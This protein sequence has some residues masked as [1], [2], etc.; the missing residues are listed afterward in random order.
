MD[1]SLIHPPTPGIFDLLFRL[2]DTFLL[3]YSISG[4]HPFAN[5]TSLVIHHLAVGSLWSIL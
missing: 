5:R 1:L 3:P 4:L 2:P